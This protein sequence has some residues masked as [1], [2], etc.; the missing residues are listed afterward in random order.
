[1][2]RRHTPPE[3]D[4]SHF[5]RPS[6]YCVL[7]AISQQLVRELSGSYTDVSSITSKE[8]SVFLGSLMK[9]QNQ[10]LG[11]GVSQKLSRYPVKIPIKLLKIEPAP[12]P[13][14]PVYHVLAAAYKYKALHEIRRWDWQRIDKIAELITYIRQELV[15]RGVLK[16]PIIML[17]DDIHP[18]KGLELIGIISRMG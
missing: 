2:A 6:T 15:R 1:M 7:D 3:I 18:D 4:L 10:H 11:I 8:L 16:Y 5:E 13:A 9:F 17:S 12:T 14:S